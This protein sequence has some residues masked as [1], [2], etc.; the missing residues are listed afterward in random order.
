L[1]SIAAVDLLTID[2]GSQNQSVGRRLMLT[3]LE[4]ASERRIAGVRLAQSADH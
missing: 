1:G 4:C 2:P 3:A